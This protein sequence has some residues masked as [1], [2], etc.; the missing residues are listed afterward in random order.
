MEN[1]PEHVLIQI[2]DELPTPAL[3]S[4]S[5]VCKRFSIVIK[6]STKLAK[7]LLIQVNISQDISTNNTIQAH[8][9][10][11]PIIGASYSKIRITGPLENK[12]LEESSINA[13]KKVLEVYGEKI[14][15]LT[16][17][18]SNMKQS[19]KFDF[20]KITQL[21]IIDCFKSDWTPKFDNLTN[22]RIQIDS[23][24]G[25]ASIMKCKFNLKHFTFIH[26][27][28]SRVSNSTIEKLFKFI[29]RH[30][31]TLEELSIRDLPYNATHYELLKEILSSEKLNFVELDTEVGNEIVDA[32]HNGRTWTKLRVTNADKNKEKF[33]EKIVQANRNLESI[34]FTHDYG[35]FDPLSNIKNYQTAKFAFDSKPSYWNS[36]N[37]VEL[38]TYWI[39]NENKLTELI[40]TLKLSPKLRKLSLKYVQ[41]KINERMQN[42][43]AAVQNVEE[44]YFDTFLK[45]DSLRIIKSEG[46]KLQK[47]F[48]N[49]HSS[50]VA[51]MNEKM[52]RIF[53]DTNVRCFVTPS[54]CIENMDN[55]IFLFSSSVCW[56]K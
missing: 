46:K 40:E 54:T 38:K 53:H 42:L 43:M 37:L 48:V 28:D 49:V 36:I 20:S 31:E 19:Y 55:E 44:I 7:N 50:R 5:K 8:T 3:R 47:V 34:T 1:L 32:I 29:L 25:I 11:L 21:R 13:V 23:L 22:L 26:T 45:S 24:R 2:F 15:T 41:I 33:I 16:F 6:S 9:I 4:A 35:T 56:M 39:S 52:L 17:E 27:S 18:Y 51:E 12:N 10:N 30:N 14:R